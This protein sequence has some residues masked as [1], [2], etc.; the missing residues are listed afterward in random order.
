VP[1]RLTVWGLLA[2][3]SVMVTAAFSVE[4]NVG[5]N[6]TL[7]VQEPPFAAT[8]PPQLSV[9]P[10]SPAFVPFTA[11]AVVKVWLPVLLRMTVRAPLVVPN[12][13]LPKVKLLVERPAT[14]AVPTPVPVRVIICG[15]LLALS[16]MTT[17]AE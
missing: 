13:W 15:L 2:A 5:V 3:L 4:V 8:E 12:D 10:K 14:G 17:E 1:E 11:M 7:I 9:S 6:V 16:V